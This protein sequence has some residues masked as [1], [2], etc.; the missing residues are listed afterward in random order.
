M[1]ES[2]LLLLST[3]HSQAVIVSHD[4]RI[5]AAMPLLDGRRGLT[6]RVRGYEKLS[7][8]AQT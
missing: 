5:E 2:W 6:A 3:L 4:P 7:L 1:D 8:H